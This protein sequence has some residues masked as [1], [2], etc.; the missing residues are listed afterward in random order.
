[1]ANKKQEFYMQIKAILDKQAIKKDAEELQELLSKT[2]VSFDTPEFEEKVTAVVQ[3]LS[4]ETMTMI[5]DGFNDSLGVLKIDVAKMLEM[6]NE[7]VWREMGKIAAQGFAGAFNQATQSIDNGQFQAILKTIDD[8]SEKVNVIAAKG[9][10]KAIKSIKEVDEAL[11]RQKDSLADI[12]NALKPQD[13]AKKADVKKYFE[14]YTKAYSEK[15]PWEVQYKWLVKFM[16]AYENYTS[17][18]KKPSLEPEWQNLYTSRL[19]ANADRRN[20]LQNI[21]NRSRGTPVV[22]YTKEPWAQ[23]ATLQEVKEI[24]KNGIKVSDGGEVKNPPKTTSSHAK[25]TPQNN[26]NTEQT[27]RAVQQKIDD[28]SK[29]IQKNEQQIAAHEKDIAELHTFRVYKGIGEGDANKVESRQDVYNAYEAD[30]YASNKKVAMSYA[31]EE[32]SYVVVAEVAPKTPLVFDAQKYV[33]SGDYAEVISSPEFLSDLKTKL[34]EKAQQFITDSEELKYFVKQV[35]KLN[36]S[37]K[38]DS[39]T[40]QEQMNALAKDAGFDS[41]IFNNILDFASNGGYEV[42]AEERASTKKLTNQTIAVLT[43]E[44]LNIIGFH[45]V[46]QDKNGQNTLSDII[47]EIPEYYHM[48]EQANDD[49]D[50]VPKDIGEFSDDLQKKIQLESEVARL[51][52]QNATLQKELGELKTEAENI[53]ARLASEESV[54]DKEQT[55]TS[56]GTNSGNNISD[57][58]ESHVEQNGDSGDGTVAIDEGAL[59][60]VLGEVTYKVQV[61]QQETKPVMENVVD[62]PTISEEPKDDGKA[63]RTAILQELARYG[64]FDDAFKAGGK[65]IQFDGSE[66]HFGSFVS[67]YLDEFLGKS[68]DR[69]IY[70]DLWKEAREKFYKFEPVELTKEDAI[71]IIREKIPDNILDG[72]FRKGD[73]EYKTKLENITMS[74]DEIRNAALNIMWSNFKEFSGKDIGFQEFLNSE[75]PV[76]RGKNSENYVNGDELLAFSFDESMAKKFGNHVLATLIKPIDTLGAFQTTAEAETLVYRKQLENRTEYQQWHAN[77]ESGV[78]VKE[79]LPYLEQWN[80]RKEECVALLKKEKLSYEDI[81]TLVKIYNDESQQKAAADAKDWDTFDDIVATKTSIAGK[82]VPTSM[83]GMGNDSP[84]KWLNMVG[85]SAESAAEKLYELYNRM[86]AVADIDDDIKSYRD[87]EAYDIE[88]ENGALEEKLELLNDIAAR[89]GSDITQKHRNRY[90]SLNQKDMDSGLTDK[91]QDT[92]SELEEKITEAD[93]SLEEFGETYERII[94]KLADGKK[95]VITPSDQGLRML[96]TFSDEGYGQ[97]YNGIEIEDVIFERV[98]KEEIA[99]ESNTN[100]IQAET[101]AQKDLNETKQQSLL[102]NADNFNQN[103]FMDEAQKAEVLK[104]GEEYRTIMT[105]LER[106]DAEVSEIAGALRERATAIMNVMHAVK[107]SDSTPAESY[108]MY[109]GGSDE[110]ARAIGNAGK[111]SALYMHQFD[112]RK[113][114]DE[115]RQAVIDLIYKEI[116]AQKQ[117]AEAR[118]TAREAERQQDINNFVSKYEIASTEEKKLVNELADLWKESARLHEL[119]DDESVRAYDTIID[120]RY[121]TSERL[122]AANHDLYEAFYDVNCKDVAKYIKPIDNV[123]A[124]ETHT[125]TA[126]SGELTPTDTDGAPSEIRDMDILLKKVGDVTKAIGE[127]TEAFQTEKTEVDKVVTD[128]IESLQKLEDKITTIKGIFEGLVDNIRGD[129]DDIGAGLNNVNINVNYPENT[130]ATLDQEALNKLA[131]VIK[132]A[133]TKTPETA[134]DAAGKALATENTL[135]AIKTAVESIDGKTIKGSKV[136]S[137]SNR[138]STTADDY[139]GSPF[140]GEKLKTREMELAKFVQ[141]LMNEGQDT[142]KMQDAVK[143]LRDAL[144]LVNSGEKL[145]VWDQKFRQAKLA[146]GIDEL[147]E[148]PDEQESVQTYKNL[149][150]YAKEYYSIVEKHEKAKEGTRRKAILAQ[151]KQDTE[152]FMR[153][154]G[155]D[156]D[157]LELGDEAYN[158]KLSDLRAKHKRNLDVIRADKS[159]TT[160]S[161]QIKKES[162]AL[163]TLLGLYKEYGKFDAKWNY[164]DGKNEA[165]EQ[166]RQMLDVYKKIQEQKAS[167]GITDD[168]S[169]YNDQIT[170][171]WEQGFKEIENAK[172]EARAKASDRDEA[173]RIQDEVKKVEKYVKELGAL[174][175]DLQF[176]SGNKETAEINRQIEQKQRYINLKKEELELD[177][178]DLL[179][180]QTTAYQNKYNSSARKDSRAQD[181]AD[182]AATTKRNNEAYE[183]LVQLRRTQYDIEK[184]LSSEKEGSKLADTY[185]SQLSSI[186]QLI[187]NQKTL[188]HY[189]EKYEKQLADMAEAHKRNKEQW[190]SIKIDD[191]R[192]EAL[193]VEKKEVKELADAYSELGKLIAARNYATT[194]EARNAIQETINKRVAAI[195]GNSRNT[196]ANRGDFISA[197][198]NSQEVTEDSLRQRRAEQDGKKRIQD[199]ANALKSLIDLEK[200]HGILEAKREFASTDAEKSEIDRQITKKKEEIALKKN[201]IQVDEEEL[202]IARELAKQKQHNTLALQNSRAQGRADKTAKEQENN[203]AYERL[204]KLKELQYSIEKKLITAEAGSRK[205][206]TYKDQLAEVE[207][208]VEAQKQLLYYTDAVYEQKLKDKEDTQRRDIEE[209]VSGMADQENAKAKKEADYI[210]K[211]KTKNAISLA[212]DIGEL[213]A[214]LDFA[215]SDKEINELIRQIDELTQKLQSLKQELNLNGADVDAAIQSA[216]TDKYNSLAI[217]DSRAQGRKEER[218]ALN[219]EK[220]TIKELNDLYKK[221]GQAEAKRDMTSRNIAD[222]VIADDDYQSILK[223]LEAKRDLIE[224]DDKLENQFTDSW[225]TGVESE[226]KKP[227][228]NLTKAAEAL[229]MLRAEIEK[230]PNGDY[231]D[232]LKRRFV[233]ESKL[234]EVESKRLGISPDEKESNRLRAEDVYNSEMFKW[235][236]ELAKKRDKERNDEQAKLF[237]QQIKQSKE[238][239]KVGQATSAINKADNTLNLVSSIGGWSGEHVA[240]LNEYSDKLRALK[241]QY[242]E[243]KYSDGVV[244]ADQQEELINQTLNVNKLTE[245]IN[246]LIANYNRLSGENTTVL[247]ADTLG[248]N[249]TIG[250]YKK[251]LTDLVM[252]HTNG[253]AS[254]TGFNAATKELTYTVQTDKYEFTEYTVA[255]RQADG[256]IVKLA[257]NTKRLETPMEKLKRKMSEILTYFGGSSL[258][259][260]FFGQFRQG[261]QYVRDID[262]ALTELKK[263][264]DETEESYDRFLNTAAK[265]ADKVGSTITNIVSSTA[266]W[267]RLGFSMEDAAQLAESTSVLLNV[268]EFSSIEDATSALTSTMQAF[269]YVAEDSMHVVDVLNEVGNNFAISS[270]G[271]ATA[272]QDSA[273]ALMAANNSYEEAVALIAAA[274]RV[275]QDPNSV[276]AAL[277]TISLRLRGTSVKDLEEAGEDTTGAI[278]SKS[279]LR[280]QIKSLSGVDILTDTGAYK[281]TYQI[282]LEIS[283]VWKKMSDIDQAALLEILAG[284]NRANTAMAILSN[285][286]DLEEAYVQALEAEGSAH[287]ENEK[288]LDSIQGKMDQFNNALQTMWSH[289]LDDSLIKGVVSLGTEL[290]KIIDKIGVVGTLLSGLA[291]GSMIKG[292]TG[293]VG[294]L[295]TI[296]EL[297]AE[298]STK[299][300]EFGSYFGV[301]ASSSQP[302]SK[303]MS[304]LVASQVSLQASNTATAFNEKQ[305][306]AAQLARKLTTLG[307]TKSVTTLNVAQMSQVLQTANVNRE[308]RLAIIQSLGL[309]TSTKALTATEISNALATAGVSD[310]NIQATLSALGLSTANKG[311]AASFKTLVIAIKPMLIIMAALAAIAGIAKVID[312]LVISTEELSEELSGLKS[313]LTSIQSEL[314]SVNQELETTQS[315]MAELLAL[316]SLSFTQQEELKQLQKTN[317]ELARR[318]ALLKNEEQRTHKRVGQKA[319]QTVESQLSDTSYQGTVWDVVHNAIEKATVGAT[320]LAA[321]GLATTGGA[322]SIPG[323]ILGGIMGAVWGVGEELI[324]NRI[325]TEDKL[326]QEI[327]NYDDLIK[328]KERIEQEL[329]TADD[330][331]IELFGFKTKSEAERLREDLEDVEKEIAETEEYIDTTLGEIGAN[332]EGVNYGDGA[333]EMLDFYYDTKD[334][335][336]N[337]YGSDGAATNAIERIISKDEFADL[338]ESI[339]GYVQKLKDGDDAAA[340]EIASIINSSTEFTAALKKVGLDAQ[341]AIDYF[342]L[343]EGVFNSDTVKGIMAQYAHGISVLQRFADAANRSRQQ[344]G[345]AALSAE[346]FS[347]MQELGKGG[348]VDLFNRPTIDSKILEN[349]GWSNV[350]D[351]LSTVYTNTYTNEDETVAVN[352]TPILPNGKV[353]S[354]NELQQYAEGVIAG[355]REDNLK[356]QI[357]S[358]FEGKDAIQQAET[359]AQEIHELQEKYYED[360]INAEI[361]IEVDDGKIEKISWDDLFEDEDGDGNFT[362][363]EEEFNKMLKGMDEKSRK[364][365]IHLAENVKNGALTW[366]Q[367]MESFKASGMVDSLQLVGTQISEVNAEIFKDI[368]DDLSGVI[369]TFGEFSAALESTAAAMDL[370]H[371]AQTQMNNSGR[372][373][374]K[375]ALELMQSTD[376]WNK[377]LEIEDGNLRLAADAE[378]ILIQEKLDHIKVNLE[379][380]LATVES[381]IAIIEA[382]ETSADFATTLNE[383]TNLAVRSLAENMTYLVAIMKAYATGG[384]VNAALSEADAAVAELQ[385]KW[386]YQANAAEAIGKENLYKKKEELEAMIGMLGQIDTVDEFKNNYDFDEKPGDK[387]ADKDKDKEDA[388]EK[389]RK[390]YENEIALLEAQQTYLENE[391]ARMEAEDEQVTKDIYEEQIR[392]EKEKLALYEAERAALLTAMEGIE[393][394]SDEWYEY[395]NAVWETEH[396][397]QESTLAI[398]EFE[399]KIVDLYVTAF[400]KIEEAYGHLENLRNFQIDD[401]NAD[402]EY[403]ELTDQPIYADSYRRIIDIQ[404]KDYNGKIAEAQDLRNTRDLAV[405]NSKMEVGDEEWIDFTERIYEAEAGAKQLRN[406]IAETNNEMKE[407]YV[408]AFD[409]VKEAYD[410]LGTLYNDKQSYTE[411]WMELQELRG[412]PTSVKAYEYLMS[413]TEEAIADKTQEIADLEEK[414]NNAMANGLKEGSEEWIRMQEEIRAAD[415]DLQDHYITLEQYNQELKDLYYTAFEKIRDSFGNV[416]DVYDDQEAFIESY[417]SYLETMG[418]SVPEEVY[419]RLNGVIEDRQQTNFDNLEKLQQQLAEME[420]E[421]YTP[422]D[423]EWVAA[424]AAL[425]EV[426][427]A[428]WDDEVAQAELNKRVQELETEKFEEYVKRVQDVVTELENLYDLLADED[429]ANEDGSWTEEGIASLGLLYQK[430]EIAKKQIADYQEEIER[431]NDEYES[432]V[433][434][435]QDYN[436]RL[437]ELKNS[438]WDAIDA[439]ESAK[440]AI[441]DVNEARVDMIEE[442]IQDEI[443]AYQELI[444][445]KK[446]ELDAE[447]DLYDFRK[448]I[449]NQSKDIAALERKIAAMSGSTDAATIAERTKLEAQLREAQEELNDTYYSHAMDS[450]SSALDDEN[451]AYVTSKE[452]YIELLREALEDVEKIVS[453]TMSQVL[454]NADTVLGTLNDV[455]G[456]YGITLSDS[457]IT[458]WVDAA[459]KAE[460]FKN[461]ATMSEYEFAVQNGIFT[462][463]LGSDFENLFAQT[464]FFAEQFNTDVTITMEAIR[465]MVEEKTL[466]MQDNMVMPFSDALNYAQNTF[467]PDVIEALDSVANKARDLVIDETN[468]LKDP[469]ETSKTSV[470]AW[471]DEAKR[472]LEQVQKDAVTYDPSDEITDPIDGAGGAIDTYNK[473]GTTVENI[474]NGLVTT[475]TENAKKIASQMSKVVSDAQSAANAINN[476]GSGTTKKTTTTTTNSQPAETPKETT[477]YTKEDVKALQQVL[478]TVFNAGIAEDG[479]Y[480]GLTRHAVSEAQL[481]M[482]SSGIKSMELPDGLY[483]EATRNAMITYMNSA[484]A[485]WRSISGSASVGQGVQKYEEAKKKLPKAFYAKGTTGTKQDEWAMTDEIGDELV[486]IPG[487]DGNLQYMRKGTAVIPADISANL[488][489]WGKLNPSMD[490]SGAVQG[491]NLM[492]NVINKPELN[493]SFDALVKAEHITEETL[494]AVKKLV[495]EELDKFSRKLN[496]NL[497]RVGG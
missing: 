125:T 465:F 6:P 246:E 311:L 119:E 490:M 71:N 347:R 298:G 488:M 251:Q 279:K 60:R 195:R 42:G 324:G 194:P 89:Y 372:I 444:D 162:D 329:T 204:I 358:A 129:S 159:D 409:K 319:S 127:K 217:S 128:E 453:D 12:E 364:T 338:S 165:A 263:V 387:Y 361:S 27:Q 430:M 351:G 446:K 360:P 399:Q 471:G 3:K 120:K 122:K 237:K 478:N 95:K 287:A 300:R 227:I 268:S 5:M 63:V 146:V 323:A 178:K 4:K 111:Q 245:E 494:P 457:L 79:E 65:R 87:D 413:N 397:I 396:A 106:D 296:V 82:M 199:E 440:D 142:P 212:K 292:K 305:L 441:I 424:Q 303:V 497:K 192:A 398:V 54:P 93:E 281:S 32:D 19:G 255:L 401:I 391:I 36:F 493:L 454:I 207:A 90:E 406:E 47:K 320:T 483:G 243:I 302:L 456:K 186:K 242:T 484:I 174:E 458:P 355:T 160:N 470:T 384:D 28:V 328:E 496:Y 418:V 348:A 94:L 336:E 223:E 67:H 438:Q 77:M 249:A 437:V 38:S 408:T 14:E 284:K 61:E 52:K 479:N 26:S 225:M 112:K 84:D 197:L 480:G 252:A 72:W 177:E 154:G 2:P 239:A 40:Y 202:R 134:I 443:D 85:L 447:R 158:K 464:T 99:H 400:D 10:S 449:N 137:G 189:N 272:L 191:A 115:S 238:L 489:E 130:Q 321:A 190:E 346:E 354:P 467:S 118:K 203:K 15:S 17:K 114:T 476:V 24:L 187:A 31:T 330:T 459:Q 339:D 98:K 139:K 103:S 205:E 288:Y 432:G 415:K 34:K 352:F 451:E 215:E 473:F 59:K 290:I 209:L 423:E 29:N 200:E 155:L 266:D 153:D 442:G 314:N 257:G 381:Q 23:E 49:G 56:S 236:G 375:T 235:Q 69:D 86:H 271:I 342:I 173:K 378:Q 176:V 461:S 53:I 394:G 369:D 172:R 11:G 161:Q 170:K 436:D 78:G 332:L 150:A 132:Q 258:I 393:K 285:T 304:D 265:T 349:N 121:E 64:T 233:L 460:D 370:L 341:D 166:E 376:Q 171:A 385:G 8:I 491:I 325:S 301:L 41:V 343:E 390:E 262:S 267:S 373:S 427:K 44:I 466:N 379:N 426:E 282:L 371:T 356:L 367:A 289:T 68:F 33:D 359:A 261:V 147:K 83:M 425:R 58:N 96:E 66:V 278:T 273:S 241:D 380:A 164:S 450:K 62:A 374:V 283:N 253:K 145:S 486:L 485:S 392:L 269:G 25:S 140:F 264:T 315:R 353:L 477:G 277:R 18:A 247:G 295:A 414:L 109:F 259:Y 76:Y 389:L 50:F 337:I 344:L 102:P 201:G 280:G 179:I 313:E 448:N 196:A 219:T 254:I 13:G 383:S 412:E 307:L 331:Y 310:A 216:Y 434:S 495:T 1:M 97:Y 48:P 403:S 455:S 148:K 248:S 334:M 382:N 234:L 21:L 182:D 20:M 439:Y 126:P 275:V 395:A 312:I 43:D 213:E 180:Q 463:E 193:V 116:E 55:S 294:L 167:M 156:L 231:L 81:L 326:K 16:G 431:L 316:P 113:I 317:A 350:G 74:D 133:Q 88:R 286:T 181:K 410:A 184:K 407:L 306:N 110:A 270:D 318:K 222:A 492:T 230:T 117:L 435:E 377:V 123:D 9:A 363:K 221:L 220:Q 157:T 469:W 276:G 151:Q 309:D 368:K 45:K 92:F 417:I 105:L 169:K 188:V 228:G 208:L 22:G 462:A 224:I 57:G 482:Y 419:D 474:F 429:V 333:D 291:I 104:L 366:N 362:A 185:Q 30:Y 229:G 211:E 35:D 210:I 91:E 433:I 388:L 297:A 51:K 428:I 468:Y 405:A 144:K 37:N 365:F 416:T 386:D 108:Q 70:E 131:D 101:R 206:S 183:R 80:Q 124:S 198:R 260:E 175:A 107:E 136:G 250:D 73:S 308:Q 135:L 163:E 244:T 322:L 232:F 420:A 168:D 340:Q 404:T 345:K 152:T 402:I 149:I 487:K 327:E 472:V 475:A 452:D 335:W 357:G 240:R 411:G 138:K 141:K 226:T 256:Q 143:Q 445:L 214:Q 422:E 46:E 421:G 100:A 299:I 39:D 7:N 218:D 75:I 274:N 481:K 293:P